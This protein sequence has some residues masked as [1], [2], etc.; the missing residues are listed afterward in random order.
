M[1][2]FVVMV[3]YTMTSRRIEAKVYDIVVSHPP[4]HSH[5][6]SALIKRGNS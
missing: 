5:T 1:D 3:A 4:T 2:N 6:K